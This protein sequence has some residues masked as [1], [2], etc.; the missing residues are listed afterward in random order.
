MANP[1]FQRGARPLGAA[2]PAQTPTQPA[3]V[4][5]PAQPAPQQ[6]A[7]F[8]NPFAPQQARPVA[9]RPPVG[10]F[11]GIS[12]VR[13]SQGGGPYV[14]PGEYFARIDAVKFIV[15]P[16]MRSGAK[17]VPA[18]IVEA[19]TMAQLI[20]DAGQSNKPGT[21]MSQMYQSTHG[22]FQ[23]SVRGFILAGLGMTEE[24]GDTTS[25]ENWDQTIADVCD[26][27]I[28]PMAGWVLHLKAWHVPTRDGGVF[29]KT[30]W[31]RRVSYHEVAAAVAKLPPDLA[32]RV[33]P[34]AELQK[35]LAKEAAE[36]A[37]AQ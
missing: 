13:T 23:P 19:T 2:V 21:T 37:Q 29:T 33:L 11:A 12:K 20:D 22:S 26:Q 5:P 16:N 15:I 34:P 27:N 28:Q 4:P 35:Q 24:E 1:M 7:A 9:G 17:N 10:M 25:E 18:V 32:A 3:Y 36:A 6:P 30:K 8:P 31:I 14:N